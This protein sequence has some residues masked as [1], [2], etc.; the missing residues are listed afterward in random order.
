MNYFSFGKFFVV[1]RKGAVLPQ[2]SGTDD[3]TGRMVCEEC[4]GVS[5]RMCCVCTC[6]CVCTSA[7]VC[8]YRMAGAFVHMVCKHACVCVRMRAGVCSTI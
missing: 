7:R 4:V 1:A 3:A 8:V 6:V 5:T 2:P